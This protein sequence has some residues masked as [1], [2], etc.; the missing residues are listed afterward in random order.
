MIGLATVWAALVAAALRFDVLALAAVAT[1]VLVLAGSIWLPFGAARWARRE[2]APPA[3]WTWI[4]GNIVVVLA[5][6][7]R[8]E[9]LI[10]A[11]VA[12][13]ASIWL[14]LAMSLRFHN[15]AVAASRRTRQRNLR[16]NR[17]AWNQCPATRR[18]SS[19]SASYCR[20][21][22]RRQ[23]HPY[24]ES[25]WD[26]HSKKVDTPMIDSATCSPGCW[27]PACSVAATQTTR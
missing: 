12:T 15:L 23:L 22:T 17:T 3:R 18:K 14:A 8:I 10:I 9:M 4:A 6:A 5:L 13:N 20:D 27:V 11:L 1:A 25:G 26:S 24:A 19:A 16:A 21:P 7:S 2:L